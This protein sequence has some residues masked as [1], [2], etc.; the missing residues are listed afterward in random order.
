[1]LYPND[2]PSKKNKSKLQMMQV[3]S[4]ILVDYEKT[5]YSKI[6]E[7]LVDKPTEDFNWLDYKFTK[8]EI[9]K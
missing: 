5:K 3:V 1:M 4:R 9:G 2:I 8:I 6:I 7:P